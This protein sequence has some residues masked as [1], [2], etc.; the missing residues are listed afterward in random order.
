MANSTMSDSG[1]G[2]P[3]YLKAKNKVDGNEVSIDLPLMEY[4]FSG[5]VDQAAIQVWQL[6][7]CIGITPVSRWH[8][9][10]V[11]TDGYFDAW[12]HGWT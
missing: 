1:A 10:P 12:S 2:I 6:D 3:E 8:T 4:G 9:N 7:F 11:E 5:T